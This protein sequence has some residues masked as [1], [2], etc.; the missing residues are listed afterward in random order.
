MKTVYQSWWFPRTLTAS[1][2]AALTFCTFQTA[3][4]T[5]YTFTTTAGNSPSWNVNANWSPS[6][7]PNAIGDTATFGTTTGNGNLSLN[8][9]ITVGGIT[10]GTTAIGYSIGQN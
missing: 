6:G 10:F 4:A 5:D 8:V 3:H 1:L 2:F 7:F 9:A